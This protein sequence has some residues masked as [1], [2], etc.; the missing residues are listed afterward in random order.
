[1]VSEW[2]YEA[3]AWCYTRD[4]ITGK[5]NDIMD[6]QGQATRAEMAAILR[7]YLEPEEGE[8]EHEHED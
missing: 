8:Q 3:V 5:D 2:A 1:M 6:P 7:K 4:V